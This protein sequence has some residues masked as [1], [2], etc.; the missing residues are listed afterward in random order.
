MSDEQLNLET[1]VEESPEGEKSEQPVEV[2]EEQVS[3]ETTDDTESTEEKPD[4]SE[5]YIEDESEY[6]KQFGFGDDVTDIHS[7]LTKASE[8]ITEKPVD[9]PVEKPV[10]KVQ[11]ELPQYVSAVQSINNKFKHGD[12]SEEE[13]RI[14][15][16]VAQE[17]DDKI[18]I[19]GYG[20]QQ[21]FNKLESLSQGTQ[22]I[23][24]R[25]KE[26]DYRD[27]VHEMK[28]NKVRPLQKNELD[29]AMELPGI[30]SYTKA[31]AYLLAKDPNK[32][33]W[34]YTSLKKNA[35]TTK[36]FHFRKGLAP[37]GQTSE[38]SHLSYE[39]YH[40]GDG[41]MS[42]AFYRLSQKDQDR[43]VNEKLKGGR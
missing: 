10:E 36:K 24:S 8:L 42:P 38:T 27:F 37:K 41:K 11:Q 33:A 22:S 25:Q 29:K 35:E 23:T 1:P 19:L 43:I 21:L 32:A 40:I 7:A 18:G 13:A 20:M 26:V 28:K 2:A 12:L 39:N 16:P 6:I 3:S 31:Q 15:L 9:Q 17:L 34:F 30:D 5:G 4:D 14:I